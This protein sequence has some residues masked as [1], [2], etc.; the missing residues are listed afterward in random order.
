MSG[1]SERVEGVELLHLVNQDGE[2]VIVAAD[3]N[4]ARRREHALFLYALAKEGRRTEQPGSAEDEV[5]AGRMR[6]HLLEYLSGTMFAGHDVVLDRGI[7]ADL[8]AELQEH[9]S[10]GSL[11]GILSRPQRRKA[12]R[13]SETYVQRSLKRNALVYLLAVERGLAVSTSPVKDVRTAYGLN[14]EG[15][16]RN[17]RK[18][19]RL[20]AEA[21]HDL[22]RTLDSYEGK[23]PEYFH[24]LFRLMMV[25]SGCEYQRIFGSKKARARAA[26]HRK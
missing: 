4:A 10:G 23:Q 1:E 2:V 21:E 5:L 18:N 15:T 6:R 9:F 22:G 25:G 13:P 12:H 11:G 17:W 8:Y 20:L 3:P 14:S 7:A 16:I 26:D 24:D 19:D